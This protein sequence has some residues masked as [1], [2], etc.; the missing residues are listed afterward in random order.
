MTV[1]KSSKH[2]GI[3]VISASSLEVFSTLVILSRILDPDPPVI[4]VSPIQQEARKRKKKE[5]EKK[6]KVKEKEKKK[7]KKIIR[8]NHFS[9]T[10]AC[11][12][13]SCVCLTLPLLLLL[14]SS[15][16]LL[17]AIQVVSLFVI[18]WSSSS[19]CT[20]FSS[21]SFSFC[22]SFSNSFSKMDFFLPKTALQEKI[23]FSFFFFSFPKK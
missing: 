23:G 5:K 12:S 15:S 1:S 11:S 8:R 10:W 3:S 17:K 22:L 6:R 9:T 7:R 14:C 20:S 4:S 2:L 18:F 21:F 19:V 16:S 13:Y